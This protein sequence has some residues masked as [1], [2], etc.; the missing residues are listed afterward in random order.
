MG[1]AEFIARKLATDVPT[2]I[3]A[4]NHRHGSLSPMQSDL[5]RW[6]LRRGRAAIFADTGL[7]KTRMQL[8]W[9]D[10]VHRATGLDVLILAPLAVA[11][12]TVGEGAGIGIAVTHC[13]DGADVRPG[14]NITNY[15]RLHRFDPAR[16]GAVVLDESSCIK[17]HDTKTL[18]T[19]LDAFRN[20]PFRL[21]ATATPAPND[22]TE[23]GTH[24]EFLGVCS[25]AEMLSEYFVHDGGETQTWRLKG[26]A[27]AA[28][29]AWVASWGAMV[30]SPADLGYD[31][32]LYQLPELIETEHL[33][34]SD[35]ADLTQTGMLFA[36]EARSL[37]ERRAARRSSLD[38]RVTQC[39]AIVNADD[40]P[41]I[42]W[43]DLNAETQSLA[44]AIPGAVEIT[45]TDDP[46]LKEQRLI[47]FAAG[48]I[49]VLVTK[50][51]IAGWGL[52][53]Q[54]CARMAFVGV[55]DSF[56]AY[57]QAV[58]RCWRFGQTR[59]VHVH[60]FSSQL[61]GAVLANLRRKQADANDMAIAM[62]KETAAAVRAEI[63]GQ[64]RTTNTYNPTRRIY[65]PAWLKSEPA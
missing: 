5:V 42:L 50:P 18:A 56:E 11:R 17:H 54:H 45:G 38:H 59:P 47:D 10:A 44:K 36:L 51:S 39:A 55:T 32:S 57:Y 41:W 53:W 13:R 34:D 12:Q 27:R 46:D 30:R 22:W 19:L 16:F 48:R 64:Q 58:R 52:N 49:R 61:E 40:E 43:G 14:L 25:R 24:A 2:G 33:V 28:F 4:E 20:T 35:G 15:D 9:A 60:L 29:W 65:A 37:S 6:S 1:Y 31:A 26:H 3:A 7:G 21:C 63:A 23:L 8:A 62:A